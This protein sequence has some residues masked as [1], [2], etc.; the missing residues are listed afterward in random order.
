MF[1]YTRLPFGVSFAPGIFQ[2]V[3]EEVLQGVPNVVVYLD[4][5]MAYSNL[6]NSM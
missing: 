3:M 6:K 1:R 2:L 4:E 5:I